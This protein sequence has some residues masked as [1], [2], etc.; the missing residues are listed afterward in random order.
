M[1]NRKKSV[2]VI[3]GGIAGIQA[4]LDLADQNYKVYIIEKKPTLGGHMAQ[5]DK[6]FPTMERSICILGPKM[7]DATKHPNIT[8]L[9]SSE[10]LNVSGEAG[11]FHTKILK[12]ANFVDEKKC[13]SCGHCTANCPIEIP[14]EFDVGLSSRKAIYAPCLQG[15]P[16]NYTIDKEH[17]LYFTN[18]ACKVCEKICEAKAIDFAQK[19]K[20]IE[21]NVG[22]IIV[23]TGYDTFNP[24]K[25]D[26]WGYKKYPNVLTS[27]DLE[28]LI[29]A[30]GPNEGKFARPSDNKEPHSIAF[31]QCIGS[32]DEKAGNLYC[33]N[34]CCMTTIKQA[35]LLKEE[36]PEYEIC[37]FY[38]DIRAFGKGFEEFYR[39][40]RSN[41]VTFIR[42]KVS[43]IVENRKT[44]NLLLRFE[45]TLSGEVAEQEFDMVVLAVGTVPPK[46]LPE[47]ANKLKIPT[48][49]D[50]FLLESHPKLKPVETPTTGIYLAGAIQGPKDITT[51]IAQAKAAASSAASLLNKDKVKAET[52]VANV[53]EK[54]YSE[55]PPC[56]LICPCSMPETAIHEAKDTVKMALDRATLLQPLGEQEVHALK[57]VL[58]IGGGIAGIQAALDL[59]DQNY[60]V[61]IIEKKPTLGGHMA[62]LDKTFPTMERS[63]CILGPKMIDATKHPNITLLTSSEIL[64]VSGEAGNFHTKILK[65]ANFVNEKEFAFAQKGKVI[66]LNVGA[67]IVATGYDTFDPQTQNE[68]GYKKYPNVLTS[69]DL[70]RLISASGPNEGKLARPSDNKEPHSIA[71]IQCIGSRD[72][73]AGHSY[74]S[75]TCC[76]TSLKQAHQLK[77]KHP[78]SEICIYYIDLRCF[79]KGYEE[80]Y[81]Q[82]QKDGVKFNKGIPSELSEN[83]NTHNINLRSADMVMGEMMEHEFDMVVLAVGT[84]PPK[85]LP[86]LANKLKIPTGTDGF[87]LESHPKLK[88]VETPTPGIYLAGAIQGPKDITTTIAQAKAAASSA[89]SLLCMGRI[90]VETLKANTNKDYCSSCNLC[91]LACAGKLIFEVTPK[92]RQAKV[93][94]SSYKGCGN[95]ELQMLN[96]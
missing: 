29:S 82:V 50:G 9:T 95:S 38:I 30:S 1:Q 71:F 11:N 84:V 86:E 83:P 6:T 36:H 10:I 75:N 92:G 66:E 56:D 4:A 80:F 96:H 34:T 31:I 42:G 94:S 70:E 27:L 12:K 8:L 41:F 52:T 89:A 39:R 40:A 63:I 60:K 76:M 77:E 3:G 64:N 90:K 61:Y 24:S 58:V 26:V 15:V 25:Q 7:I 79:G 65:K 2:L 67:I 5:L 74:C 88:P 43:E 59:A 46:D 91:E 69:L 73:R 13:F 28:R 23:A 32:R 72:E 22:A 19:D 51:T 16:A 20:V 54:E 37:I 87:L 85:D 68:W 49:T 47:L 55:F 14:S 44:G 62:Q 78:E 93:V 57:S 35:I 53:N 81:N 18:G 48:G 45:D 21:L 33:S 17:C